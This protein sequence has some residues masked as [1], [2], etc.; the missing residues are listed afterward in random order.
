MARAQPPRPARLPHPVAERAPA[1]AVALVLV[2]ISSLQVGA[3][4][5]ATLFDDVGAAGAALLRLAWAG[6]IMLVVTRPRIAG[7]SAPALRLVV[8]FALVLGGM[9][10]CIYEAIDRIPLGVAVTIEFAG[11]LG[12]AVALSRRRSDLAWA[13]LAA[14]GVVLL[15][16]PAGGG[17]DAVGVA[18]ALVAAGCWAAYILIAQ[19]AGRVFGGRD[20]LALAMALSVLVPLAPGLAAGGVDL[21][22]PATLAI[23]AAVAIMSSVVPYSLETEALRTLPAHV[24]GVLMSLEPAVAALAGLAVLGQGLSMRDA[25]A[26]GLVVVASVGVTRRA[27]ATP[28]D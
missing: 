13:A 25:L 20:G 26:I 4:I 22:H 9:N 7:R 15:A 6:T 16:D 5:G 14:A 17:T 10:L 12:L 28:R 2:A 23:A 18:L 1:Q 24:F 8:P 3:A 27:A 19:R 11:P 21:L